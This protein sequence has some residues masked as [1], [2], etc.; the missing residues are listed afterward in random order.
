MI[1][2]ACRY[3]ASIGAGVR[4]LALRFEDKLAGNVAA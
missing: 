2:L 1:S 4:Q 3:I